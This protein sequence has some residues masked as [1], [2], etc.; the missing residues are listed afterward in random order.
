MSRALA[1]SNVKSGSPAAVIA[2]PQ[3]WTAWRQGREDRLHRRQAPLPGL[4]FV[5]SEVRSLVRALGD[6]VHV[7]GARQANDAIDDRA[8]DDLVPP[9][10]VGPPRHDLGGVVGA[11]RLH[12]GGADVVARHA[13]ILA[14]E[15]FEQLTLGGDAVAAHLARAGRQAGAVDDVDSDQ[16]AV[17]PLGDPCPSADSLEAGRCAGQGT[18]MAL[19]VSS[20]GF[21]TP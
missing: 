1:K 21:V 13:A 11:G 7:D 17:G 16:L 5:G 3:A 14:P 2:H 4:G 19:D 9:R 8:I 12:E 10:T 20:H 6:H 18:T 15:L